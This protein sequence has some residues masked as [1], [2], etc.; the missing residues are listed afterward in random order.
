MRKPTWLSRTCEEIAPWAFFIVLA[1]RQERRCRCKDLLEDKAYQRYT[2]L[3]EADLERRLAQEHERSDALD[4]KTVKL[5][6]SIA[7]GLS[8][9]GLGLTMLGT[10]T[11]ALDD[12]KAIA[13]SANYVTA[14]VTVSVLH[15]LGASWMALGALRAQPRHGFGTQYLLALKG[16]DRQKTQA[17]Q[18]ARQEV[19]NSI[20][21]MRNEAVFQTVRN[22]M[23]VLGVGAIVAA[24]AT[25][26]AGEC[27]GAW[28]GCSV[29]PQDPRP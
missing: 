18:L 11:A 3:S 20:R 21:Q 6:L 14:V 15:F 25:L 22:G 12:A 28:I 9:L 27:L 5:T 2:E 17:D 7:G 1:R 26:G 13:G 19:R 29:P 23:I 16:N 10:T 4:D 8:V 24:F